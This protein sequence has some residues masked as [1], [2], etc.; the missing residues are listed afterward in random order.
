M[1]PGPPAVCEGTVTHHRSATR[2]HRFTNPVSLVWLD[3]D[4]PQ[5]LCDRHPAW[6]HRWPAPAR[7]R[8]KDYGTEFG[9]SLGD[10]AR[11]GLASVLGERPQGPVRMLSQVRRW[12]WLFNPITLFFVWD[13][14]PPTHGRSPVGVVLEVTN[15]PWKERTRYPVALAPAGDLLVAEFDKAMH[16]SPF[17]G[18][19]HRYRL[20]VEDRDDRVA[21]DIDVL[22]AADEIAL[23]TALRLDRRTATRQRLGRSLRTRPLPTH[24]VSAA[25]HVQAARLWAK[26]V[27]F[28]PHPSKE[29]P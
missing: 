3:P 16:V 19:D 28:V 20:T 15:T 2:E 6:S 1:I 14:Q 12:G 17:L 22:D 23:H 4:D 7:F 10:S 8:R 29:T 9:G 25:I 27:P 11:D 24:R 21:V 26:G 13:G 18:L 5:A